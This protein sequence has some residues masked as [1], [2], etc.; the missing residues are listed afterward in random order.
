MTA[1][2][3]DMLFPRSEAAL[4]ETRRLFARLKFYQAFFQAKDLGLKLGSTPSP[5]SEE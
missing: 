4:L 2:P 5:E 1:N 3:L